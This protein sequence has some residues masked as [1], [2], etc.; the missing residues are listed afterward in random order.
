M[1][2]EIA[3]PFPNGAVEIWEWISNFINHFNGHVITYASLWIK[4]IYV[5]LT[6]RIHIHITIA[7]S[8]DLSVSY[9]IG[10]TVN[11]KTDVN[12][13]LMTYQMSGYLNNLIFRR[14]FIYI[15]SIT[16][17]FTQMCLYLDALPQCDGCCVTYWSLGGW[18]IACKLQS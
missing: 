17:F 9:D 5:S 2:D 14:C 18:D 13:W 10:G 8:S 16:D 15:K 7:S 11:D 3:Y 4:L 1:R 6:G 12:S